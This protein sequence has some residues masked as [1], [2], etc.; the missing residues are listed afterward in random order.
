MYDEF[1]FEIKEEYVDKYVVIIVKLMEMVV[2]LNVFL[3]V[4]VGVGN[5]WDEVY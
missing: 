1:V 2:S 4:E 5:N 3:V